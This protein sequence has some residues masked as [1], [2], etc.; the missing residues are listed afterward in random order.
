MPEGLVDTFSNVSAEEERYAEELEE[1]AVKLPHPILRAII[2]GIASDSRKHSLFYTAAAEIASGKQGLLTRE[3][4]AELKK[5]INKHIEEEKRMIELATRL[6]EETSDPRLALLLEAIL[7]DEKRHHALL[8]ALAR[9]V[10]RMETL[11][12]DEFWKEV[13][14]ESMRASKHRVTGP[15]SRE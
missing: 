3:E 10:E 1:L 12:E 5:T 8:V 6:L 2:R 11:D 4:L 7:E 9:Q 15:R 14:S 13:W